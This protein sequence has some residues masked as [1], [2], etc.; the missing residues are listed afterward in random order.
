M[1]RFCGLQ[2]LRAQPGTNGVNEFRLA[3]KWEPVSGRETAHSEID[4]G[5]SHGISEVRAG[6]VADTIEVAI[7]KQNRLLEPSAV[8]STT[9]VCNIGRIVQIPG[10]SWT[11]S[12]HSKCFHQR[13]EVVSGPKS[14]IGRHRRRTMRRTEPT[15]VSRGQRGGVDL[16]HSFRI[17]ATVNY[18]E[19]RWN[20][21]IEIS[22]CLIEV[23]EIKA[24]IVPLSIW[25]LV[26]G[27][28][29]SI[30]KRQQAG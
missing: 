1:S 4:A 7:H 17:A 16:S 3:L 27:I 10:V 6:N 9:G 24:V 2:I 15:A 14:R 5:L 13:I 18:R 28:G 30:H 21:R 23:G 20:I 12:G 25:I 22:H 19:T 11:K 26:D 8:C 29:L